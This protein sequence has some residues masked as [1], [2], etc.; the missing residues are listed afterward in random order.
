MKQIYKALI[1][2]L[3]DGIQDQVLWEPDLYSIVLQEGESIP[4]ILCDRLNDLIEKC[5]EAIHTIDIET[6]D[7]RVHIQILPIQLSHTCRNNSMFE[8]TGV[9]Y[10]ICNGS[11]VQL[12]KK[13]GIVPK[14][15]DRI[16]SPITSETKN[17]VNYCYNSIFGFYNI[18]DAKI[19]QKELKYKDPHIICFRIDDIEY[20]WDDLVMQKNSY[21]PIR[22]AISTNIPV[23]PERI[24]YIKPIIQ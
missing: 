15:P 10:R 4:Q 19:I 5:S 14:K 3:L 9:A 22:S 18:N 11:D 13:Y 7:D 2:S 16:E 1:D 12:Y 8:S 6:Y 24:E 23:S 17:Q 21:N 20:W